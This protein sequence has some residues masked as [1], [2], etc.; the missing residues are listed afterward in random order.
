MPTTHPLSGNCAYPQ[1]TAALLPYRP[2][3]FTK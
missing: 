3:Y 1:Q 2:H